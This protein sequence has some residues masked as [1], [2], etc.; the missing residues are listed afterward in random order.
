MITTVIIMIMIILQTTTTTNDNNNDND[1]NNNNNNNDNSRCAPD[2]PDPRVPPP[3]FRVAY[4]KPSHQICVAANPHTRF[5]KIV[6]KNMQGRKWHVYG[7]GTLSAA[8]A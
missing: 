1:N 5:A 4:A 2:L 3:R 8:S 6:P 7:S